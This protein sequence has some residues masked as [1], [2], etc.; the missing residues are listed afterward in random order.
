M[1]ASIQQFI[2]Q[3]NLFNS[4]T[5]ILVACS[6]GV[7]S[8]VLCDVL[9]KLNFKI[10]IAH[11]NFQL[12]DAESDGD[13]QFVQSFAEKNK[14]PFF[15]KNFD[16][17]DYKKSNAISTQMAARTLRYNWFEEI[18]IENGYHK[19]VTAHHLDDQIETIILNITKGTGLLGLTGIQPK[20]QFIVRP[21]LSISKQAILLY[22]NE[23]QIAYREDSS[24]ATANYQRNKLRHQVAPVL[25][26][27]NPD[28][29]N[30]MLDFISKMNDYNLLST[31]YLQQ[32]KRK[33]FAVKNDIV[34]IKLG[35]IHAHSA[36]KTILF[37][38]IQEFGFNADQVQNIL[39][40]KESGKQFLS[41]THRLIVDRK[42]IFIQPLSIEKINIAV[43]DKI[44]NQMVFNNFTIQCALVP[45]QYL[46]L[47]S[48]HNYAYF[49]ADKVQ[50]PL[51]IRYAKEGD[52]FYPLGLGK[53]QNPAKVGKKK[54]S[55]YFKDEKLSI[56]EKEAT[57]LIFSNE[58][59]LWLVGHRTDERFKVTDTTKMVLKMHIV[60]K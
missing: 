45:I 12:R 42:S 28:F 5:P 4:G 11:C 30:T 26:E 14:L 24:N 47:K 6:G 13:A 22:A 40:V 1:L 7:D 31:E 3:H 50:F 2:Q 37:H 53:Q 33:C 48:S 46:N 32:L 16:T 21:L 10:G 51:C 43:F 38:L 52:Y 59:L 19:I 8:M 29:S 54:I 55:K 49:D 18:R 39:Q 25:K 58:K 9:L 27:I 23:Q 41:N 57:P 20:N 17:L 56:L 35:F 15:I 44:P 36:S 34:E 60:K